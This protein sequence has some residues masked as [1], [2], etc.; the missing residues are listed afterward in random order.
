LKTDKDVDQ[1]HIFF[2]SYN[3]DHVFT[4]SVHSELY[5]LR[6]DVTI[7]SPLKT[8]ILLLICWWEGTC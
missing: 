3:V 4:K 8:T 2:T 5:G 6:H 7:T 1:Y